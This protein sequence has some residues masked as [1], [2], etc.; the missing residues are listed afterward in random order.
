[1]NRT[2][3]DTTGIVYDC[4]PLLGTENSSWEILAVTAEPRPS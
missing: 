2:D 3:G 1:M 4:G